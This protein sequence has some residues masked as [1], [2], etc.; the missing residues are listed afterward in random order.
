M[1]EKTT[2]DLIKDS[3]RKDKR[4]RVA[5]TIFMIL[6]ILGVAILFAA[7]LMLTIQFQ[8]EIIAQQQKTDAII[9]GSDKNLQAIADYNKCLIT[10]FATH[11]PP[12]AIDLNDLEKCSTIL[13]N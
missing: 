3:E 6:V 5:Q 11:R 8:N 4:F 2:H 7:H 10:V 13:N 1:N 12:V 9:A